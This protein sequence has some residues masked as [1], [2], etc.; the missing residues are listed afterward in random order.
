MTVQ[1]SYWEEIVHTVA[2]RIH[3]DVPKHEIHPGKEQEVLNVTQKSSF[4]LTHPRNILVA[5]QQKRKT[6]KKQKEKKE[7]RENDTDHDKY[8]SVSFQSCETDI[9]SER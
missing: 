9:P 1:E 4:A 3:D 8:Y 5:L 7:L 2:Y 6:Q